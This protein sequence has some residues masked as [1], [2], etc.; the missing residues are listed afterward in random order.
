MKPKS[1]R[2][3]FF[4]RPLRT[5]EASERR[6][7]IWAAIPF[8]GLDALGSAAYGPEAALTILMPL[9]AAGLGHIGP[10]TLLIVLLLAL[11]QVS[12]R[13]TIAAYPDGGGSYRV[14]SRN[15]GCWP[16]LVAGAALW[17]DY[18][19][20][21]AVAISAG[22]GALV[23]AVPS[24]LPH[25]LGICLGILLLLTVINLRGVRDSGVAFMLPTYLF[26]VSLGA[27]LVVGVIRVVSTGGHPTPVVRPPPL[28]AAVQAGTAWLL[29]RAFASGCTAMTGV[30]AVSDAVPVFREPRVDGA[31]RTLA[32]IVAMLT[33]LLVGV[34]VL[35]VA[36][37]VGATEP[38][39]AGYQ[40][41]LSQLTA[42][43]VGRGTVYYVTVASV[44]AVLCLSANTSFADF[45]RLCRVL[46]MDGFLPPGFAHQGA[47]LVY[48]TGIVLL[49]FLA[50]VLLVVFGG[51]TDRLIPLFAVG[52]FLAFTMSQLGMV[53]HWLRQR[54]P[55]RR[56]SLTVNA[57]GA[58]ATG[59]TLIVI[60]ISKFAE[61]AWITLLLLGALLAVFRRVAAHLGAVDEDV[62][63]TDALDL[64]PMPR[65]MVLVPMKRLDLVARKALRFA[66]TI[67]DDVM[68][69]QL[70]A[71]NRGEED[72]SGAW[73]ARVQE[74]CRQAALPIPKLVV[75]R[76]PYREVLEPLVRHVERLTRANPGRPIVVIVPEVVHAR[77]YHALLHSHTSTLLKALLVQRGGPQVLVVSAPWYADRAAR[78]RARVAD[79]PVEDGRSSGLAGPD[80]VATIEARGGDTHA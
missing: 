31:K 12:Y 13:Q 57:I 33:L 79:A 39:R 20:N 15:L 35:S 77:W 4:G 29:L 47:R 18:V 16:G 30:E 67:T 26:V 53:A 28:H 2:D 7:G 41:V 45:P 68:A 6:I 80:R 61:G 69:V 40:S 14:A 51:L 22:T 46:A 65:P 8:L 10:I 50:G 60:L 5:D 42:A 66:L 56:L 76:S 48:S 11:V 55:R 34:A 19:L 38:G 63:L 72:L 73:D 27:V 1:L 23:S 54:P 58:V 32:A 43:V 36:Y 70:L 21:V 24:L 64:S 62:R 71:E 44:V 17:L 52:A 37:G 25:T 75:L 9:G 59:A 3:L 74:P 49:A 78:E